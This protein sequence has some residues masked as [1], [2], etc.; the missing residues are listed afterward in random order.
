MAWQVRNTAALAEC[1][2]SVT[3]VRVDFGAVMARL[4][5]LRSEIS[6]N[7]S[8]Q[9][10]AEKLGVNVFLGYAR[11]TSRNTVEVNGKVLRFVKAVIATGGAPKLLDIP[12]MKEAAAV[13][14]EPR[15]VVTSANIFNLTTLPARLC[16]IGTGV[17][18][19]EMAQAFQRLGSQVHV[20]GR[21]GRVLSKEDADVA[22][23]LQ[24][25]LEREGVIFHLDVVSYLSVAH[26]GSE[27]TL[28]VATRTLAR[29]SSTFD[30]MLV[31]VGRS[32]N[33]TKLNLEA[34]GVE[35]DVTTGV[36]VNDKL[37]TTND[38]IFAVGDVCSPFQFTHA[39]DFMARMVIRNALF[40]GNAKF[41]SLLIPWCTYTSPEIAHVGLYA[42][43]LEA[44]GVVFEVYEKRYSENDRSI[45]DSEAVGMVRIL[46]K[47]GTDKIVGATIIGSHAGEIISEVSLAIQS[48]TGLSKLASVIHPYPTT[49]DAIRACGDLYNRTRLTK[50]VRALF[51]RVLALQR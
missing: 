12:G 19:M 44:R 50:T 29:M 21:S 40:F 42:A 34:A 28:D 5:R 31:A 30:V 11:F 47:K 48:G 16:V 14:Q 51:R 36:K 26:H 15:L 45:L 22:L 33:V 23:L 1:G 3:D 20:F 49:A 24:Q 46:C 38:R 25:E 7:D 9:R 8:A 35:F 43:D 13:E 4:R 2:I 37:Q 32:P 39:S 27:V 41:S 17:V 18:G 10:F 6:E